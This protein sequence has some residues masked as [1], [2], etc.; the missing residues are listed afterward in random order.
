M[1]HQKHDWERVNARLETTAVIDDWLGP[2]L[3]LLQ[4]RCG[5][6]AVAH[7]VAWQGPQLSQRI[8]SVRPVDADTAETWIAS[9][10]RDYCDLSRKQ[11]ETSALLQASDDKAQLIKVRTSPLRVTAVAEGTYNPPFREWREV[12]EADFDS[13]S[14]KFSAASE[15]NHS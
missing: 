12:N 13:W 6:Y 4:C 11:M 9:V 7:L 8:L 1:V 14:Q 5:Q 3:A 15:I 2:V 10:N